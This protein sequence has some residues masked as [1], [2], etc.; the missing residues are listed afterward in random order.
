MHQVGEAYRPSGAFDTAATVFACTTGLI[1]ALVAAAVIWGWEISG[2]PTL[3]IVTPLVHGLVIG[4]VLVRLFR[5]A[6]LRNP[7]IA[8][9]LALICASVSVA[10]VHYGHYRW[11]VH[12]L[13]KLMT[14]DAQKASSPQSAARRDKFLTELHADPGRFVDEFVLEPETGHRGFAGAMLLRAR[15]GQKISNHG[16]GG[17]QIT[18]IGMWILWAVEAAFVIGVALSM[19]APIAREPFCETCGRW[20]DRGDTQLRMAPEHAETMVAAVRG[21]DCETVGRLHATASNPAT[22]IMPRVYTCGDCGQNLADVVV[23]AAKEKGGFTDTPL[24]PPI[25]VSP[26]VAAALRSPPIAKTTS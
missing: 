26:E 8:L 13:E 17:I 12:D 25:Y 5:T 2:L 19:T 7:R 18:G 14:A 21:G 24:T 10:A 15:A 22:S 9:A 6:R 23:H 1:A 11:L 16:S 20:F 3:I 4:A